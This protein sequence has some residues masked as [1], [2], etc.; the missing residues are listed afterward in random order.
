MSKRACADLWLR[1]AYE[2]FNAGY[3]PVPLQSGMFAKHPLT[4]NTSV[5]M[6][7]RKGE[8]NKLYDFG[9]GESPFTWERF[10]ELFRC[11]GGIGIAVGACS[12]GLAVV[13][14]DKPA[15][16]EIWLRKNSKMAGR[17][18]VVRTSRGVHYYFMPA[19]TIAGCWKDFAVH[20]YGDT[21]GQLKLANGYVVAPP[22][23]HPGGASY[24]WVGPS[25][26]ERRPP[27]I[28]LI[29]LGL[30][31]VAAVEADQEPEETD[32]TDQLVHT[33]NG[34]LTLTGGRG[35][36]GPVTEAWNEAHRLL[37]R[38]LPRRAGTRNR[39]LLDLV[40]ALKSIAA[41]RS[42][43]AVAF[44]RLIE[45]WC[46]KLMKLAHV[47]DCSFKTNWASFEAAWKNCDISSAN[48]FAWHVRE[49]D[50]VGLSSAEQVRVVC[51]RLSLLSGGGVFPL[52]TVAL[53]G[54]LRKSQAQAKRLLH[55]LVRRHELL[56]VTTGR[57]IDRTASTYCL[58]PNFRPP[59]K[60]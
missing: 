49:L 11:A 46:E 54:V 25:I 36:V 21:A 53:A 35:V 23:R 38:H 27:A 7:F 58:G 5:R 4:R 29:E 42:C 39:C 37:R 57:L 1:A 9:W 47:R 48:A 12:G 33:L 19:C 60:W 43:P 10:D 59:N 2:Y 20:G 24:E 44:R 51:E 14:F 8:L 6:G 13:D 17:M 15:A 40:R 56:K 26:L 50:L 34:S 52:G 16:H 31:A 32:L 55:G 30:T 18:P 41:L 3:L 22:T 45:T 28:E